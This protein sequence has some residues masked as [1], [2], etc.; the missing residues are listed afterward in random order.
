MYA[1]NLPAEAAASLGTLNT[2]GV[3]EGK[4]AFY[5]HMDDYESMY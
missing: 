2:A 4:T 3:T 5:H 1:L